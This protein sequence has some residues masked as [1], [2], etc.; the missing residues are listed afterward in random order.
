MRSGETLQVAAMAPLVAGLVTTAVHGQGR[1]AGQVTDYTVVGGVGETNRASG[2][3]PT[4]SQRRLGARR[5]RA[6]PFSPFVNVNGTVVDDW[7]G[8]G[9]V[10]TL[11]VS[12]E[13]AG[14]AV[15]RVGV[16]PDAGDAAAHGSQ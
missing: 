13:E 12:L 9:I 16:A 10:E 1:L 2:R 6:S 7:Y 4:A 14:V 5:A 11:A 15:V 3:S 8:A